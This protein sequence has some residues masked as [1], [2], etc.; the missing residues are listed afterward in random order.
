MLVFGVSHN[1][2]ETYLNAGY[3]FFRGP[4]PPLKKSP[5]LVEVLRALGSLGTLTVGTPFSYPNFRPVWGSVFV[6]VTVGY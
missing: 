2:S 3:N 4:I 5:L 1:P 6:G